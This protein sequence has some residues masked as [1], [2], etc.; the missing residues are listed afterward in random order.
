MRLLT[1]TA[2]MD[3]RRWGGWMSECLGGWEN[4]WRGG[5]IDECSDE[6]AITTTH[7]PDC[8][9]FSLTTAQ[10]VSDSSSVGQRAACMVC[11]GKAAERDTVHTW[12]EKSWQQ[13]WKEEQ[14]GK[15]GA[16]F[17]TSYKSCRVLQ[18]YNRS[19]CWLGPFATPQAKQHYNVNKNIS[20]LYAERRKSQATRNSNH[21]HHARGYKVKSFP[22]IL[23]FNK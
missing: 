22:F 1:V 4:D 23:F 12:A 18:K 2:W 8:R 10:L 16:L 21:L 11:E 6:Q 15:E 7:C 9:S 17:Y 13:E 3:G 5:H 14:C 19:L 20:S